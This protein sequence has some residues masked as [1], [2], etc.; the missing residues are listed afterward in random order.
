M[1]VKY[2][3]RVKMNQM[4]SREPFALNYTNTGTVSNKGAF[5]GV[6][7]ERRVSRSGHARTGRGVGGGQTNPSSSCCDIDIP[8]PKKPSSQMSY[9]N[10]HRRALSGL[11]G[12]G[13]L[14]SRV[15]DGDD[16]SIAKRGTFQKMLTFKRPPKFTTNQYIANKRC[17]ALRCE[18]H[19]RCE[20]PIIPKQPDGGNE[21]WN[22]CSG[23]NA[24]GPRRRRQT[25][26]LGFI[27]NQ[28]MINRRLALRAGGGK[29]KVNFESNMMNS[30]ACAN[31]D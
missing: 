14:A 28:Q 17:K 3:Q 21:C 6:A 11:G 12:Q 4:N 22:K 20:N 1:Q 31:I 29:N 7:G 16:S 18:A 10:Y 27:S 8:V 30:G 24:R 9:S 25:K 23:R 15:Q 26:S 13:G 19:D 2:N 5:V